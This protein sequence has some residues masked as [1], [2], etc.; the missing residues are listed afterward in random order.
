MSGILNIRICMA[1]VSYVLVT[2]CSTMSNLTDKVSDVHLWPF[3]DKS[4]DR[5]YRPENAS[6]Y[7]CAANKK[8]FLRTL[9]NGESVWL[10]L[11]EREVGLTKV[12]KDSTKRYSNGITTLTLAEE[13]TLE[14]NPTTSYTACK[15]AIVKPQ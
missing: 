14:I 4:K 9:D 2:G 8:F 10:I 15:L 3:G 1:L 12:S 6:E 11:P 13:S 7:Q 5:S